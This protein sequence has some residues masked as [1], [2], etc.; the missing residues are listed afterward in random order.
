MN[1]FFITGTSRGIGKA[2]AEQLLADENNFVF[3][4]ARTNT[5]SH[6]RFS[7]HALDLS[8]N[9]A[10]SG[11]E[12]PVLKDAGKICLVNNAG[13]IGSVKHAGKMQADEIASAF[14]VNLIAPAILTNTFLKNYEN[15]TGKQ[16]IINVSSGAGKNPIDGW[17]VYCA[18]KAG[19]DM[20]T[21]TIVE[22]LKIDGKRHIY[23]FAVAPGIVDTSMQDQIRS[24]S[25]E[26]FSRIDQFIAY[27]NTDQLAAPGLVA[28]KFLAILELPEKFKDV[29]FSVKDIQS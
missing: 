9:A 14:H 10:V 26:N 11:W 23:V 12:F 6:E 15:F 19:L 3:G 18:T 20:Y 1:Y 22:E 25:S 17:S 4:I 16:V 21:K 8:D 5:I 29:L 24:G 13:I 7:F 28:G 27:K 2:I